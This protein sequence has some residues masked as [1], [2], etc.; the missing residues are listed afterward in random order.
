MKIFDENL[1][2]SM[3]HFGFTAADWVDIIVDSLAQFGV[4][5]ET[6]IFAKLLNSSRAQLF[7]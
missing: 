4:N 6:T 2:E 1:Q 5:V 7:H 3:K